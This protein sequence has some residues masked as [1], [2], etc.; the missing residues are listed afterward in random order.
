MIVELQSWPRAWY[1]GTRRG[2]R[3]VCTESLRSHLH[4]I[5]FPLYDS[6]LTRAYLEL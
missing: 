1:R 3:L 5:P 6:N 4:E 2:I